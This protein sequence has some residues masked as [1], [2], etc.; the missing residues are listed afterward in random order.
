[1]HYI[2]YGKTEGRLATSYL[3][4]PI[5]NDNTATAAQMAAF[6][7]SKGKSFNSSVYG[8]SLIHI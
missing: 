5:M 8:L 6:F 7:R 2:D 4:P 1:M 3:N